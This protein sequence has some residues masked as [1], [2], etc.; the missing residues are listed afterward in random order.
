MRL[1]APHRHTTSRLR[2]VFRTGLTSTPVQQHTP[3]AP[4]QQPRPGR[5]RLA[6]E[7]L[8][9]VV[10][11]ANSQGLLGTGFPPPRLPT[12]AVLRLEV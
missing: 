11:S 10:R 2:N 5:I 6:H 9:D 8:C 3:T 4:L 1:L 7:P 12:E